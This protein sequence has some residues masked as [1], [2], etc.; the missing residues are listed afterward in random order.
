MPLKLVYAEMIL[1]TNTKIKTFNIP[2]QSRHHWRVHSTCC[3]LQLYVPTLKEFS[4]HTMYFHVFCNALS[5]FLQ[6]WTTRLP[7]RGAS[8]VAVTA[9]PAHGS[10]FASLPSRGPT[11]SA[12]HRRSDRGSHRDERLRGPHAHGPAWRGPAAA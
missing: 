7:P 12:A 11:G 10:M 8:R 4:L 1:G 2:N 6:K 5:L 9:Q 3:C